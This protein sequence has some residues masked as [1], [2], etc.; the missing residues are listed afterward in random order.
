MDDLSSTFQKCSMEHSRPAQ[1]HTLHLTYPALHLIP[2]GS[3]LY[4]NPPADCCYREAPQ[5]GTYHLTP[6]NLSFFHRFPVH[7]MARSMPRLVL[8]SD[9]LSINALATA[10]GQSHLECVS[11]FNAAGVIRHIISLTVSWAHGDAAPGRT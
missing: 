5:L 8:A 1:Y 11:F 6:D 4:L 2:E 10:P 3:W 9:L 7:P